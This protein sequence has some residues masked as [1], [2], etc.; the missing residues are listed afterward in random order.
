MGWRQH[1]N[2]GV[3]EHG[4]RGAGDAIEGH[5][6]RAE[7]ARTGDGQEGAAGFRAAGGVEG[8]RDC[9]HRDV[10]VGDRGRVS[11]EVVDNNHVDLTELT[12]GG[13]D[14]DGGVVDHGEACARLATEGHTGRSGESGTGDGHRSAASFGA[15]RGVDLV[16][17][18]SDGD[19]LEVESGAVA[20]GVDDH[21]RSVTEVT[22]RGGH[23][24]GG[25]VHHGEARARL[26]TEGHSR[27]AGEPGANDGD[28]GAARFRSFRGVDRVCDGAVCGV[29]EGESRAVS[30]GVEHNHRGITEHTRRGGHGN[31]GVADHGEARAQLATEGH[32]RGAEES[33][34]GDGDSGATSLGTR[35]GVNL[36][37]NCGICRVLKARCCGV[38]RGVQHN[39]CSHTEHTRRGRHGDGGVV[40]HNKVRAERTREGDSRGSEE[41]GAGECHLSA[42]RH[43]AGG[44]VKSI[45]HRGIRRV[46]KVEPAGAAFGV[47]HNHRGQAEVADRSGDR[48]LGVADNH[49]AGAQCAVE[50]HTGGPQESGTRDGCF[51]ATSHGTRGRVDR[52]GDGCVGGVLEVDRS[53]VARVVRHNNVGVPEGARG[54]RHRDCGVVDH[55]KVGRRG[56]VEGH[57]RGPNKARARDCR[58]GTTG[59]RA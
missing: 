12:R 59:F 23:G 11:P 37:S 53:G 13:G 56:A 19:V 28:V 10:F 29:F 32:T 46:L 7:E 21:N 6:R 44:G 31:G 47:N 30:R 34:T 8:C 15:T 58:C 33:G 9:T 5:T 41:P 16:S 3:A 55:H 52:G 35:V 45:H 17:D 39:H 18:R 25:V 2:G 36:V 27:G 22:R 24:D 42:T 14:G 1:Q 38:A 49:K 26:S 54:G 43:R 48:D 4:E 51:G 40:D 20:S 57:T 50:G